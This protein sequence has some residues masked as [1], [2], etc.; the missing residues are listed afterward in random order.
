MPVNDISV[1]VSA[2]DCSCGHP[3]NVHWYPGAP[4][5][6]QQCLTCARYDGVIEIL[7]VG[8]SADDLYPAIY[9]ERGE[10]ILPPELT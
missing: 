2:P 6:C 8:R 4:R 9:N 10:L 3:Q 1:Y 5:G 7:G